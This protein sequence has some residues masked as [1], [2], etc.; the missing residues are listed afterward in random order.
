ML[1]ALLFWGGVLVVRFVTVV[2]LRCRLGQVAG[3]L[4]L[5]TQSWNGRQV[6]ASPPGWRREAGGRLFKQVVSW[7]LCAKA[8]EEAW[9]TF[10]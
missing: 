3:G 7:V 1:L 8:A 9:V 10:G 2:T 4:V 5:S 6:E